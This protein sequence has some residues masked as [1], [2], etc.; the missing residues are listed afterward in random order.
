MTNLKST[1]LNRIQLFVALSSFIAMQFAVLNAQVVINE[2][3]CS[4][5]TLNIGGDNEDF[6]EF[7]NQGATDVD[8]GGYF[9]SDQPSNPDKFEIPAGTTVQAGGFTM[10]MCSGEGELVT[11]LY[12]GGN[13][14]TNFK[15]NQCQGESIIFSDPSGTILEQFDYLVDIGTTQ[16]DHSWARSTD[17][18]G[19]W[20]VCV[21]PTPNATNNG[22]ASFSAYA[23]TPQFDIEAGYYTLG[24]NV[25]I[26]APV[27]YEVRYTTDGYAPNAGSTLYGGP[28]NVDQSSPAPIDERK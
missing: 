13:L 6:I 3:S 22:A 19:V 11:N 2:F 17:G 27:G 25:A 5:Y 14:N 4:N 23:P 26:I 28:I 1:F 12:V 16:A 9:L 7:F 8:L 18:V 24:I 21:D 20:A 10:I 15:I